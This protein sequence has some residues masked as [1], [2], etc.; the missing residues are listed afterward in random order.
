MSTRSIFKIF[1]DVANRLRVYILENVEMSPE[2]KDKMEYLHDVPGAIIYDYIEQRIAPKALRHVKE[3]DSM[4]DKTRFTVAQ[5][6]EALVDF[7]PPKT[8]LRVLRA[9]SAARVKILDYMSWF[10][11]AVGDE[12]S[13]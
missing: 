11:T 12:D 13:E 7:L 9:P 3:R 1:E 8:L 10:V 2:E 6:R 5:T 4:K